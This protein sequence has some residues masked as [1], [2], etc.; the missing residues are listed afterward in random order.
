MPNRLHLSFPNPI[1][2]L[3]LQL[4]S[5][6]TPF[7]KKEKK[8]W[9]YGQ[10]A[11]TVNSKTEVALSYFPWTLQIK[12]V[13]F[14]LPLY[15]L[16]IPIWIFLVW[17]LFLQSFLDCNSSA[18]ETWVPGGAERSCISLAVLTVCARACTLQS[19]CNRAEHVWL[20][21]VCVW[22]CMCFTQQ[23]PKDKELSTYVPAQ[24]PSS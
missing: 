3:L 5:K 6:W 15:F 2:K 22:V 10:P 24:L 18:S 8:L 21:N 23:Q 1:C 4:N 16:I 12:V 17:M 7:F 19:A 20:H 11:E 14:F 9:R 13:V